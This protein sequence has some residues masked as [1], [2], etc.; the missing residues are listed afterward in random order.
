MG[1]L[2]FTS[3]GTGSH[4]RCKYFTP[5]QILFILQVLLS[6]LRWLKC[7]NDIKS[8]L[9]LTTPASWF[10]FLL[11]P[12]VC[13]LCDTGQCIA[14]IVNG[15]TLVRHIIPEQIFYQN[16]YGMSTFI[17]PMV[18]LCVDCVICIQSLGFISKTLLF[19]SLWECHMEGFLLPS[20]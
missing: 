11:F 3:L 18:H 5:L 19:A 1:I 17:K 4:C 15:Y 13:G 7:D 6:S 8:V 16:A 10:V 20:S 2:P 9:T 14:E 12:L